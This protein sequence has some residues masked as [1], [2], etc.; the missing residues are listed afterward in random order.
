[1]AG[2]MLHVVEPVT[3]EYMPGMQLMHCVWPAIGWYVPDWHSTQLPPSPAN[4]PG[5][6]AGLGAG[7]GHGA[8]AGADVSQ[9]SPMRSITGIMPGLTWR[10]DGHKTLCPLSQDG[11]GSKKCDRT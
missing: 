11:E 7:T 3:S 10:V 1:M 4:K 6:H 2:Q 5:G 9:S 8:G